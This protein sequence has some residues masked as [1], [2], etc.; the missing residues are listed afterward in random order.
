MKKRAELDKLTREVPALQDRATTLTA[1][2]SKNPED[3]NLQSK[4]AAAVAQLAALQGQV[5]RA[6]SELLAT[7]EA[8]I[9]AKSQ[10]TPIP[11]DLLA[12]PSPTHLF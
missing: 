10:F 6:R 3:R 5:D 11:H 7:Q 4:A 8:L 2:L 1:E 9:S 12:N